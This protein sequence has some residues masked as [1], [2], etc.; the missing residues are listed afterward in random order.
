MSKDNHA[1][2]NIFSYVIQRLGYEDQYYNGYNKSNESITEEH[3][4]EIDEAYTFETLEEAES[5]IDDIYMYGKVT[6]VKIY[7]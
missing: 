4:T 1:D 6:I 7:N 2:K 3:F 5:K